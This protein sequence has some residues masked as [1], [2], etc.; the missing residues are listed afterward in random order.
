MN[1][2]IKSFQVL[3]LAVILIT[4][5]CSSDDDGAIE[6]IEINVEDLTVAIDENPTNGQ[7]IG[8]VETDGSG[9][10]SF[11]ITSQTPEGALSIDLSTGELTVANAALFDFETNPVITASVTVEDAVSPATVTINL[12]NINEAS[13]QD[14]TVTIDENPT[15]GQVLGTVPIGGS[16]ASNFDI[17]SQTPEGALSID[18][19]TGELTV[20]NAALFDFETNPVITATISVVDAENPATVTINLNNINEL[21]VQDLTVAFDENPTDGQVVDAIQVNGGGTLSFSITSQT[22]AGALN[23]NASTGELTVADPNLFDFETNPVIT[24]TIQVEDAA[25]TTMVTATINLNDVDEIIVQDLNTSMDENP[26][27]GDTI[28]TLLATGGGSLTY[29][30]TFQNPAGAFNIDANTGE[31]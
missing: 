19:S 14:L 27:T 23:I 13:I 30:I 10:L 5:G 8:T 25:D 22:P 1:N 7:V 11:S 15:N 3:A 24:A 12:T 26:S 29:A 31:L 9:T 6:N 2:I 17:T 18:A 21:S 16:G 4:F 20:D 28:G